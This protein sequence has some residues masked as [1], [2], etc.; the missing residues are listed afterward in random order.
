LATSSVDASKL[1]TGSVSSSAISP[2][3]VTT[4]AITDSAVTGAKIADTSITTVKLADA[5]VNSAK[6]VD[7]SIS[8]NDLASSSVTTSK[9]APGAVGQNAIADGS[10]ISF[11][12]GDSAVS[13]AKLDNQAVTARNIGILPIVIVT[14][15]SQN[16]ANAT[17]T[18]LSFNGFETYDTTGLHDPAFPTR[19][20]ATTSGFYEVSAYVDW[21]VNSTGYRQLVI[22]TNS[23]TVTSQQIEGSRREPDSANGKCAMSA[24]RLVF[25]NQGS[26]VEAKVWQNSGAA[27]PTFNLGSEYEPKFTMRFVSAAP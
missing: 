17:W 6:I 4:N 19:L 7:F 23:E 26:Y 12:L 16:V 10:V 8:S 14:G 13:N 5:S 15:S 25:L 20:T 22:V 18:A 27:L 3:A 21:Q 2:G 9:I 24:R 1:A 11:K